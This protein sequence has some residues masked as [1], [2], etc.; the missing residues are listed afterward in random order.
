VNVTTG[1]GHR[2][3]EQHNA[4]LARANRELEE[5]AYVASHDLKSPLLVVLGFL[6]LLER[7]KSEQ[8]D[9][10]AKSYLSAAL[11]G[12]G[13]MEELIDDLLSYSRIGRSDRDCQYV[14]LFS[15][16]ADVIAERAE[17]IDAVGAKVNVGRLPSILAS[18]VM[19]R[20]LCDNLIS[21]A[22]KFRREGH[23]PEI[24]IDAVNLHGEWL[25]RVIDNG[26][27]IPAPER[28]TIF[29]M[30]CRLR[31]TEDRPGSGVGLAICHR[32]VQAHGGRLWVEDGADGGAALC[33]TLPGD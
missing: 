3:L 18:P 32:V 10:D 17:Q 7:T 22:L 28:D 15:I 30:F 14:D 26:V 29:T 19:L 23:P 25:I 33:F 21:N 20:Q 11:R 24:T 16:I 2:D 5:F 4:E 12:A 31:Q 27:G 1:E 9:D 8:L 13:R 6:D